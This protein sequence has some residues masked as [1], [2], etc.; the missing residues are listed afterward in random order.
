MANDSNYFVVIIK[1]LAIKEVVRQWDVFKESMW[2]HCPVKL[3]E[4]N[5]QP[6]SSVWFNK[7]MYDLQAKLLLPKCARTEHLQTLSGLRQCQQGL[8]LSWYSFCRKL[9]ALICILCRFETED[10]FG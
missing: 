8:R 5:V 9:V 6:K 10:K 2:M 4:R 7:L 1:F 3:M